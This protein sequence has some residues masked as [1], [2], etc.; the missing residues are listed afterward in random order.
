MSAR[1][2]GDGV[3]RRHDLR[4]GVDGHD[5][6]PFQAF[7]GVHGVKRHSLFLSVRAA[8]DGACFVGPGC[9]HR[10]GEGAQAAHRKGAA[11][12]QIEID[13]GERAFGLAAMALEED[14]AHAQHVDRLR[15]EVMWRGGVDPPTQ[16]LQLFDHVAG[17]GMAD[18]LGI[19]AK[20]EPRQS[21]GASVSERGNAHTMSSNSSSVR[22]TKRSA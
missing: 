13:I 22:P 11:E 7:G 15:Q 19:D 17:K 14:R 4:H 2:I 10:L 6:R 20:V 8:L 12:R 3:L 21:V 9:G 5:D 16:R 1:A 18:M